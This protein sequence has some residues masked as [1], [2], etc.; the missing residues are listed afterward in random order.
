MQADAERSLS[1][2]RQIASSFRDTQLSEIFQLGC[3]LLKKA[4][5]MVK[6]IDFNDADQVKMKM[7]CQKSEKMGCQPVLNLLQFKLLKSKVIM[8]LIRGL[9]V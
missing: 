1:K 8:I 4:Q 3:S 9:A 6:T 2:H 5:E 7:F